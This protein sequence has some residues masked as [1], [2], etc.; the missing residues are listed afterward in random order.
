[1]PGCNVQKDP[2]CAHEHV[3][4]EDRQI[5]G[6]TYTCEEISEQ[7]LCGAIDE[8]NC[9]K[10]CNR[11][12]I[13]V[14]PVEPPPPVPAIGSCEEV[15]AVL[16]DRE[17]LLA[18]GNRVPSD[19]SGSNPCQ[20]WTGVSCKVVD[21]NG[22]RGERVSEVSLGRVTHNQFGGSWQIQD[23]ANHISKVSTA[24]PQQLSKLRYLTKFDMEDTDLFSTIPVELSVLTEMQVFDISGTGNSIR[25]ELPPELSSWK[26]IQ[27]FDVAHQ[28]VE[29]RLPK[30]YSEW[31][32]VNV[33]D[34]SSSG[35]GGTLPEEWSAMRSLQTAY[36]QG[37]TN[38]LQGSIPLSWTALA[39]T[40]SNLYFGVQTELCIDSTVKNEFFGMENSDILSLCECGGGSCGAKS[41]E[42]HRPIRSQV[43]VT[44]PSPIVAPP[45]QPDE[46]CSSV[47]DLD[48]DIEA[49]EKL[50]KEKQLRVNVCSLKG[51]VC[52]DIGRN[53]RVQKIQIGENIHVKSSGNWITR[54]NPDDWSTLAGTTIPP[55]ISK[56]RFLEV[57]EADSIGLVGTIPPEMSVLTKLVIFDIGGDNQVSGRIPDE[58]STLGNVRWF[59]LL[60]EKLTGTIPAVFSTWTQVEALILSRVKFSGTLPPEWGNMDSLQLLYLY[61]A[62][63]LTGSVPQ[64]WTTLSDTLEEIVFGEQP[65][66]CVDETT[67]VLLSRVDE[68]Q[69]VD[70]LNICP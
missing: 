7:D 28:K 17:G 42:I 34:F 45:R 10:S 20:G 65:S 3:D 24:I 19:W 29:A 22:Q 16:C 58:L 13:V 61:E 69:D 11:C 52:K 35:I 26:S 33:L 64:E 67:Q 9:Q 62:G 14:P 68:R 50:L 60:Q 4:C 30:E 1:M 54:D 21:F 51:I 2:S 5:E 40:V 57:F 27:W 8:E 31:S 48:C 38:Q 15:D 55:E 59:D 63:P 23:N 44:S 47:E 39:T 53:Q 37:T 25:G 56:M 49:L 41:Q 43:P 32:W 12:P 66:L 46:S 36:F 6:I 18:L 70:S